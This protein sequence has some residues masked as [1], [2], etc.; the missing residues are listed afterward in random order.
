MPVGLGAAPFANLV[1]AGH[2][3]VSTFVRRKL[4]AN[5]LPALGSPVKLKVVAPVSVAII[6][7][8]LVR[9]MAL[10]PLILPKFCTV[11]RPM[12]ASAAC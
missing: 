6:C 9:S 10:A 8:P 12:A 3:I 5:S 11:D 7:V 1:P 2:V 4:N